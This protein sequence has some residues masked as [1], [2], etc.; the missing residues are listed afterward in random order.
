[1]KQDGEKKMKVMMIHQMGQILQILQII[2]IRDM[3]QY[4]D[5]DLDWDMDLTMF[6]Y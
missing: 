5:R 3:E 6:F 4:L 2:M 1:M